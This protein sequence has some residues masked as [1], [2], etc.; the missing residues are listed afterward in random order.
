MSTLHPSI[1]CS[2]S[3]LQRQTSLRFSPLQR[4]TSP[5]MMLS[6]RRACRLSPLVPT[7]CHYHRLRF[8][9]RTNSADILWT[10]RARPFGALCILDSACS[11][12]VCKLGSCCVH[13]SAPQFDRSLREGA[14]CTTLSMFT[15]YRT[16][17]SLHFPFWAVC[18]LSGS[19][20]EIWSVSW[21]PPVLRIACR[22]FVVPL[23]STFRR[24]SQAE[25]EGAPGSSGPVH[26]GQYGPWW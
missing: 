6:Q 16:P 22:L 7:R 19:Q 18:S 25:G 5:F 1:I 14:P 17:R 12:V 21:K 9:G 20:P 4:T 8:S 26:S 2:H 13:S 15:Y 3:E 10:P 23:I 11:F 24:S